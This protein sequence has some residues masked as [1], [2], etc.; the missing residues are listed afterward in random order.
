M[1]TLNSAAWSFWIPKPLKIINSYER[2][3][4]V[5][6][7]LKLSKEAETRLEWIIYY[8]EGH[9]ATQTARHFGIS[10]KTFYKWYN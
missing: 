9:T 5:T 6:K 2:Y 10:R 7:I 1:S 8:Q 4:R 3:R